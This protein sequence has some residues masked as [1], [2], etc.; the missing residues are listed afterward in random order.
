ML[1]QFKCRHNVFATTLQMSV[2]D[3]VQSLNG[4]GIKRGTEMTEWRI[5]MAE[6]D[7]GSGMGIKREMAEA[8]WG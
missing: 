1:C 3:D 4:V 7:G 5:G 2:L 8:E 6:R